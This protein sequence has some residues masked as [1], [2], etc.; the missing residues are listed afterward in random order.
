[1]DLSD[2][3][4]MLAKQVKYNLS[5]AKEGLSNQYG[6]N[7]GKMILE[8]YGDD[9]KTKM[10]AYAAAGSDARMCG[11]SLPVMTTSGSGNQGMTASLP[12]IIYAREK[13]LTEEQMYRGLILASLVTIHQKRLLD[14]YQLTVVL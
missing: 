1:M 12:I 5:I 13:G 7:V 3:N 10:K 4:E 9:V 2:L 11:C 6:V 8:C 14:V